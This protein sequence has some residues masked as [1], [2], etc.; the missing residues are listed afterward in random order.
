MH[1]VQ[2]YYKSLSREHESK[3]VLNIAS[4]R[5]VYN[6]FDAPYKNNIIKN[7]IICVYFIFIP[8]VN[9]HFTISTFLFIKG[10]LDFRHH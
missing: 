5:Q 6:Q 10:K 1:I 4:W 8:N 2:L 3:L 7:H 9:I